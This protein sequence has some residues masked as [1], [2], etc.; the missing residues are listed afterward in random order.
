MAINIKTEAVTKAASH[1]DEQNKNIQSD[2]EATKAVMRTLKTAWSGSA[3]G[4]AFA[5]YDAIEKNFF[6][7][8]YNVINNMVVFMRTC[9]EQNYE[10]TETTISTAASAFK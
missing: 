7:A 2:V 5:R 3:A 1:I 8:R 10:N 6:E 9:V 4:E